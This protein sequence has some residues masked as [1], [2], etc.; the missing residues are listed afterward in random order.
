MNTLFGEIT[1][2]EELQEQWRDPYLIWYALGMPSFDQRDKAPMKQIV[3]KF[4]TKED[5][6]HFSN[7]INQKLTD[8]TNVIW[9]PIKERD[10]NSTKRYVETGYEEYT[11]IETT[12]D[13]E[14]D[15]D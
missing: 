2:V 9:Y 14:D 5:R 3:V 10:K 6:D 8:R 4:K 13:Y 7:V 12:E 11:M 1:T 15:Q